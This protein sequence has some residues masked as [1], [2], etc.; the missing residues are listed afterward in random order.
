[1]IY[2]GDITIE[3]ML[4][5]IDQNPG[6]C[7]LV[8]VRTAEEWQ[9]TGIADVACDTHTITI[10]SAPEQELMRDYASYLQYVYWRLS[11][12]ER[13]LIPDYT[14][15]VVR[16]VAPDKIGYFICGSGVRSQMAAAIATQYGITQSY[17]VLEGMQGWTKRALPTKPV[18]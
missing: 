14:P 3:D 12:P 13:E 6:H 10:V 8:D 16:A 4:H 7:V 11:V 15:A 17:N 9:Q 5:N 2:K 1:M 18:F